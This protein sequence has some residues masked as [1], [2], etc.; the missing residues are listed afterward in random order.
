MPVDTFRAW[1]ADLEELNILRRY[2]SRMDEVILQWETKTAALETALEK[3]RH[4]ADQNAAALQLTAE[5][6]KRRSKTPGLGIAFGW[7][8][9][10]EWAA[11]AGIVWKID[12]LLPW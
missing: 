10:D 11:L 9:A 3:E 2:K 1:Q 12:G 6:Y 7:S 8:S 5:K 4:A